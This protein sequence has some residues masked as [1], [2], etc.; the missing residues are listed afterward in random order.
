[1]ND[2]WL[3]KSNTTIPY[4]CPGNVRIDWKAFIFDSFEEARDFFRRELK[5]YAFEDNQ[6]FDGNG[7]VKKLDDF[8]GG[9][10]GDSFNISK[11]QTDEL[12]QSLNNALFDLFSGKDTTVSLSE[13]TG[14]CLGDNSSYR[15]LPEPDEI[16]IYEKCDQYYLGRD[17]RLQTNAFTMKDDKD[18]YFHLYDLYGHCGFTCYPYLEL[19]LYKIEKNPEKFG[20]FA[21]EDETDEEFEPYSRCPCDICGCTDVYTDGYWDKCLECGWEGDDFYVED[22]EL[23]QATTDLYEAVRHRYSGNYRYIKQKIP[24]YR[25]AD[26]YIID[27]WMA[28]EAA[29]KTDDGADPN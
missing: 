17:D 6:L 13:K 27:P 3:F 23:F 7:R 29:W 25:W 14:E 2:H 16:D 20:G 19:E 4:A 26:G 24:D 28:F 18:Y 15:V 1:M 8:I 22:E 12:K 9:D 11:E 21:D 10:I 5:R